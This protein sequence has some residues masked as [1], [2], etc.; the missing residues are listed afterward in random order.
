M[1]NSL[2]KFFFGIVVFWTLSMLSQAEE[3][4][5]I[6]SSSDCMAVGA[7]EFSLTVGVGGRSNPLYDGDDQPIIVV[8]QF[9]WYGKHFFLDNFDFGYTLLDSPKHQ[10]NLLSTL[11]FEHIYFD[12]VG[13]GNFSLTTN[14]A[15]AS[16]LAGP[17]DNRDPNFVD[18]PNINAENNNTLDTARLEI[19]DLDKRRMAVLGGLEYAYFKDAWQFQFQVLSDISGVHNG[20][21]ARVSSTYVITTNKDLYEFTLGA[22]WQSDEMLNYYYGLKQDEVYAG[23]P[24]HFVDSGVSSLAKFSWQRKLSER[25]SLISTLQYRKLGSSVVD[26]PLLEESGVTTIFIGGTYHF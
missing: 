1:P 23:S 14:S 12:D 24:A 25:W 11:S 13:L 17:E 20:T 19:D 15:P 4:S 7:W 26:S 2:V 6:N 18:G 8:P 10:F 9:A 3:E 16:S 21:E 5:C 22:A